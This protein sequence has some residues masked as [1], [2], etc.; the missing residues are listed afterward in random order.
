MATIKCDFCFHNCS[1]KEGQLGVC[2]VRQNQNGSLVSLNYGKVVAKAIDPI[3]KKPL[4]HFL[5]GTSTYSLPFLGATLSVFFVK[6]TILVKTTLLIIPLVLKL[7]QH[8]KRVFKSFYLQRH[9]LSVIPTVTHSLA[10]L[11][12]GCRL[13]SERKWVLQL[14]GY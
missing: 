12:V 7:R 5:P 6:I 13:F 9:L 8:P 10:R 2:E 1:L 4:Y 14:Y 11:Y 3:E